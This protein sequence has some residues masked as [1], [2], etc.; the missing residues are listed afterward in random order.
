MP[1]TDELMGSSIVLNLSSRMTIMTMNK[2][3][4][5]AMER[6]RSKR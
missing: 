1:P 2:A 6:R 4:C 5:M 3:T